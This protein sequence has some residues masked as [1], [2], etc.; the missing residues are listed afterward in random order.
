MEKK[1]SKFYGDGF[2]LVPK[3]KK[4]EISPWILLRFQLSAK[5]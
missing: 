3:I 4:T 1:N 2:I 5:N